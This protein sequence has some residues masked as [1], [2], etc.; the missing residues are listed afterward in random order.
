VSKKKLSLEDIDDLK[1]KL[2]ATFLVLE[3]EITEIEERFRSI[4]LEF[5]YGNITEDFYSE[6]MQQLSEDMVKV[7]SKIEKIQEIHF[8]L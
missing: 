5:M 4:E 1:S 2:K 6:K 3:T 8:L 7:R